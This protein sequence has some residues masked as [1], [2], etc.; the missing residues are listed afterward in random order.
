MCACHRGSEPSQDPRS[1]A[2]MVTT[3][4]LTARTVRSCRVVAGP[5][6]TWEIA[7]VMADSPLAQGVL[8]YPLFSALQGH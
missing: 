7:M 5:P 3:C 2:V 6:V 8:T 4:W 1:S